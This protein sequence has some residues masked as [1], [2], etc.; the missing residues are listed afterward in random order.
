MHHFGFA[1]HRILV[2]E[3]NSIVVFKHPVVHNQKLH[4]IIHIA[5]NPFL[6]AS[7]LF[8][9]SHPSPSSN[10]KPIRQIIQIKPQ[11]KL[12]YQIHP[13]TKL[14]FNTVVNPPRVDTKTPYHNSNQPKFS[15]PNKI[16]TH[17]KKIN[18]EQT[19]LERKALPLPSCLQSHLQPDLSVAR[20]TTASTQSCH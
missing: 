16:H 4:K 12:N 11:R 14:K 8:F 6:S 3:Q 15:K 19:H 20:P 1:L 13:V 10:C 9:L 2:S 17:T 18:S 7:I 5:I